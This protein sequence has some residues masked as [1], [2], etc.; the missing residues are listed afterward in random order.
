[1]WCLRCNSRRAV[2]EP[3]CRRSNSHR[4][5][6]VVLLAAILAGRAK[7]ALKPGRRLRFAPKTPLCNLYLSMLDRMGV[8]EKQFGDS[9]GMLDGLG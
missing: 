1:M 5:F 6:G 8:K 7:G 3:D 9:T 2:A 4:C